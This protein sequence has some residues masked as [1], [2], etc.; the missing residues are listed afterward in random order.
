MN[1]PTF[2][3]WIKLPKLLSK[4]EKAN[5]GVFSVLFLISFFFL[6]LSFYFAN[7]K[8]V[9]ANGGSY[10]EGMV[11]QPESLNPIYAPTSE[12]DKALVELMFAGLYRY[13]ANGNIVPEIAQTTPD[14]KEN[15]KVYEIH[16][17]DDIF[18]HD[19][20]KL[21][22]DDVLFTIK[23]IQDADYKSPL[24]ANWLGVTVEKFSDYGVRFKLKNT[25]PDFADRLTVKIIPAHVWENISAAQFPRSLYNFSQHIGAG[26]YKLKNLKRDNN[27]NISAIDLEAFDKY[28]PARSHIS[29]ITF[30]FFANEKDLILNANLGRIDGLTISQTS[31][32][33][34]A[35][36][37]S[38]NFNLPR[39]F[40]VFFNQSQNPFLANKQA[41]KAL[42]LATNKEEII[43]IAFDGK[44]QIALSPIMP[45]FY[46]F[47]NA[48]QTYSYNLDTAKAILKDIDYNIV[49]GKLI[50]TKQDQAVFKSTLKQGSIGEEVKK[51][52]ECLATAPAGGPDIYSG[53]ISGIFDKNTTEAVKKFQEKYADDILRPSGLS[54]GNGLVKEGTRTKL[55]EVCFNRAKPNEPVKIFLTT[56]DDPSIPLAKTAELLKEQWGQLGIEVQTVVEPISNLKQEIIRQRNYQALIF[57]EVLG[58]VPDPF[59]FWHSSQTEDPGLNL[60]NYKNETVDKLLE[61]VRQEPDPIVRQEKY[62]KFQTLLL[63]DAPA[64][65]LYNP[66]NYFLAASKVQ[67]IKEGKGTDFAQKFSQISNWYIKTKRIWK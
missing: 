63:D 38:Y 25:Y 56:S 12:A 13:D 40:A 48:S 26:P 1:W 52:Q 5:L 2:E 16:L 31:G 8:E 44:A 19:G 20:K 57:G 21:T 55:N 37:K 61:Q 65:F 50:R 10:I 46:G 62:E 49:D 32:I 29:K 30:L 42:N 51:L 22:A 59:P 58:M 43:K 39:Y 24:R 23:T 34:N 17:R 11:G 60:A 41:R 64:V 66:N 28:K 6:V 47:N 14:I 15:G 3:Q 33:K 54:S 67:G 45:E 27:G 36:F 4:K 7:T 53:K 35:K 18:F 9:P